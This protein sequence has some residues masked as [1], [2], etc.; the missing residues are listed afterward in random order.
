MNLNNL[1]KISVTKVLQA[2]RQLR[3]QGGHELG[4]RILRAHLEEEEYAT[5]W[6][7]LANKLGL[8]SERAVNLHYGRFAHA[9]WEQMGFTG[10]PYDPRATRQFWLGLLVTWPPFDEDIDAD[11]R[12]IFIL[13]KPIVE[14][15]KRLQ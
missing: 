5:T 15:L 11:G 13:R 10:M 12:T 14:A 2:M 8:K 3:E 1:N 6:L 4:W 9:L 7:I